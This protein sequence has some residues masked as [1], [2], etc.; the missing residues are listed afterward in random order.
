MNTQERGATVALVHGGFHGP[1]CWDRV[2]KALGDRGT[3]TCAVD[4][5]TNDENPQVLSTL[6]ENEHLVRAA[7]DEIEGPIVLV[8]HSAGGRI[9]TVA[10]MGQYG[11]RH[12]VYLAAFMP[13]GET[14]GVQTDELAHAI[15]ENEDG[16]RMVN[17]S[18][19][20]ELFYGDCKSED[21]QWAVSQLVPQ[22]PGLHPSQARIHRVA[23]RDIP[24]TYIV[25]NRDQA[26]CPDLQRRYASQ[27]G[28]VVEWDTSHSPFL[29]RPDLVADLLEELALRYG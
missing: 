7:L 15:V 10:A 14:E 16:S 21:V 4:R 24:S 8:G 13:G 23:W 25:C 11:V 1:W 19:A 29:S 28:E 26:L 2:V 9:I 12:L 5:R 18:A 3:R 22:A 20:A 17:A 6:E 27:A